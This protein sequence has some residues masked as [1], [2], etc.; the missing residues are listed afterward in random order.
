LDYHIGL[1]QNT[2][3]PRSGGD[4]LNQDFE[5]NHFGHHPSPHAFPLDYSQMGHYEQ[6]GCGNTN[7]IFAAMAACR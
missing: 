5:H 4:P 6:S 2:P 1:D 3:S 7:G